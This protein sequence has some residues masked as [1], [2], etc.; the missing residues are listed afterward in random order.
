[1]NRYNTVLTIGELRQLLQEFSDE[2]S[3]TIQ[4]SID[5]TGPMTVSL[6]GYKNSTDSVHAI[7]TFSYIIYPTLWELSN[8]NA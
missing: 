6:I 5:N 8:G 7:Y 2:D 4:I 3:I 1:M